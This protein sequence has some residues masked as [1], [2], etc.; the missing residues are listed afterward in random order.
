MKT[1]NLKQIISLNPF[2][3]PLL[4]QIKIKIII[5]FKITFLFLSIIFIFFQQNNLN[6][7]TI[8]IL[9]NEL[10]IRK[11]NFKKS[12]KCFNQWRDINKYRID[13]NI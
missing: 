13:S 6:I 1:N 11:N 2:I 4:F 8:P 12:K 10:I 3:N 5:L 7:L 9:F